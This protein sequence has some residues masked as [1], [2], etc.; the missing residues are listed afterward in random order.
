MN[1]ITLLVVISTITK[2]NPLEKINQLQRTYFK[3][4]YVIPVARVLNP[5]N[6][7]LCN[8]Q[9]GEILGTFSNPN[10]PNLAFAISFRDVWRTTDGGTNWTLSLEN[11]MPLGGLLSTGT[12]GIVV[13]GGGVVWITLNAGNDW[14]EVFYTND[15]QTASFDVADT[16]IYL[17]DSIPP[18][19]W[20]STNSG[21][22]WQMIGTFPNLYSIDQIVHLPGNPS[23]FWFTGH[24]TPNDTLAY[25]YF[26]PSGTLVDTIP[27]SEVL[28]IQPSPY[29]PNFTLIATDRGI[30]QS[31]AGSGPWTRINEPFVFGLF[32]PVDIE[33][34]GNDTIVVSSILNPGIFRGARQ[35]GIWIFS[36]VESREIGTLIS[37]GGSGT[38]YAGSLGKGVYKSTNKGSSWTI[39]RNNLYAHTFI[40]S[41]AVSYPFLDTVFYSIGIGG[42]I[43]RIKNH[44]ATYDTLKNF[45]LLGSGIESAPTNPDFLIAS[46]IDMQISGTTFELGTIFTSTDG[47]VNWTKV[48]S[49]YLPTDFVITSN[50][51]IIIGLCDTFLIRSTTGGTAFTPVFAKPVSLSNLAG[52]DTIFVATDDSVFVSFDQGAT[53]QFLCA[54]PGEE[55]NE[56]SYDNTREILYL[57]D[58]PIYRYNLTTGT[59]D[60]INFDGYYNYTTRVAPNGNLYFLYQGADS[61][62]IARSFDTGNTI[63]QEPFPIPHFFGGLFACNGALFYYE[64]GRRFWVSTDITHYT[65]EDKNASGLLPFSVPTLIRRGSTVNIAFAIIKKQNCSINIYDLSGRMIGKIFQGEKSPGNHNVNFSTRNWSA[66]VY[67]LLFSTDTG[68]T[69]RKMIIY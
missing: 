9:G 32:Q 42:T 38:F 53:W 44:G 52:I 11:C 21:L 25:I 48:D 65:T 51:N 18:R 19:L 30:Y 5:W 36:Y 35:Y 50:P 24:T 29:N 63:D 57:T 60:S 16:V 54:D 58:V 26:S 66:G 47:G 7:N 40:S 1:L 45:L 67:F 59:L 27:A 20:R 28:D 69:V 17:V 49:N 22:S 3:S 55:T 33:F 39:Q 68:C 62:Y 13:D 56:I 2:P 15:F 43:Y 10:S 34:T 31:T 46:C 37:S 64:G 8:L 61:V 12:R 23:V 6:W 4:Q 14:A 41:G